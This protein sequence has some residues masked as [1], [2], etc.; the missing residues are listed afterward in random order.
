[1]ASELGDLIR[2]RRQE[3]GMGLREMAR[4]IKKSPSFLV[5]LETGE[6]RPS[7]AESTLRDI[8]SVLELPPDRLITLAGKVPMDVAP[9]DELEAALF[10]RMKSL[11]DEEKRRILKGLPEDEAK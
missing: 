1:M 5:G 9:E 8:A 3:L 7:A 4:A 6:G 11:P 10:R 2:E